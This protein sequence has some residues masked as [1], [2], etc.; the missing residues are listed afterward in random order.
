MDSNVKEVYFK[1]LAFGLGEI[2]CTTDKKIIADTTLLS[3][4]SMKGQEL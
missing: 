4:I 3:I 2:F 1:A